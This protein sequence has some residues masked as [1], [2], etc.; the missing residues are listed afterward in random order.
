M[1]LH[2]S[3]TYKHVPLLCEKLLDSTYYKKLLFLF[4]DLYD[5]EEFAPLG[6]EEFREVADVVSPD[7]RRLKRMGILTGLAIGLHNF[8]E[9]EKHRVLPRR[10]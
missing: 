6:P 8:P 3:Y 2:Q 9:G 10:R 5:Q 7:R 1:Y 4:S